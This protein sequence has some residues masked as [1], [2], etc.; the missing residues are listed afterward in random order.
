MSAKFTKIDTKKTF[1]INC[2]FNVKGFDEKSDLTPQIDPNYIFDQNLTNAILAGISFNKKTLI[3]GLHGCGKSTHIEQIA[4]RLNWGVIRI[5]F[6]ANIT[7]L[8]LV[9]RDVIKIKDHKQITEFK[10]GILPYAIQKPIILILDEYDAISPE[11]AFVMQ[12]L[13][14]DDSKF[15]LFEE[16]KIIPTNKYFRI[17]ATANTIGFGDDMGI[18]HG[19]NLINQ[20]SL[21]RFNIVANFDYL[22]SETEAKILVKKTKID[23]KNAKLMVDLANLTRY[24]FKN[25]DISTLISL[26]TLISWSENYQIFKSITK[27]FILTFF[28]RILDDEKPVIAE[29]FQRT[30]ALNLNE[31]N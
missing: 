20:A 10:L 1:N 25:N 12:R 8:E 27:S 6:D 22:D 24:G 19:T 4:A 7:R 17:F 15:V 9:G 5:N 30:F 16:N 13:L 31:D 14:E 28:N 21:D 26:R 29:Y 18:Y 3:H 11:I 2:D 23:A